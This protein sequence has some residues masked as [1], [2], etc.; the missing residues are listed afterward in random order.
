MCAGSHVRQRNFY[1]FQHIYILVT[2]FTISQWDVGS[3]RWAGLPDWAAREKV[4][5]APLLA[6]DAPCAVSSVRLRYPYDPLRD[7]CAERHHAA[8][9]GVLKVTCNNEQSAS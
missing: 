9:S 7:S 3:A 1:A 6:G 5:A 8:T 2:Y 4:S